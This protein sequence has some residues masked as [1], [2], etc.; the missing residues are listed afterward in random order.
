MRRPE[1][2]GIGTMGEIRTSVT[3]ENSD[4]R[5]MVYEGHGLEADVRRTTIDGIVDTGAFNLVLPE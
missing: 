5:V 3:L 1:G 2:G 4:D